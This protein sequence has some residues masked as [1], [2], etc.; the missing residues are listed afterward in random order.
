MCIQLV[1]SSARSRVPF[2]CRQLG[3]SVNG[4]YISPWVQL[5]GRSFPKSVPLSFPFLPLSLQL[6]LFDFPV[7]LS[8]FGSRRKQGLL[9]PVSAQSCLQCLRC[10][11]KSRRLEWRCLAWGVPAVACAQRSQ[12]APCGLFAGS[13]PGRGGSVNMSLSP[14]GREPAVS[15]GASAQKLPGVCPPPQP[16]SGRLM[17][18]SEGPRAGC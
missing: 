6:T 1:F 13:P 4:C 18:H 10:P 15:R 16:M 17:S 2:K 11:Q 12:R 14:C 9:G 7:A 8:A 5:T 3:V